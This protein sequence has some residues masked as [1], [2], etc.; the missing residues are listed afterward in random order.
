MLGLE[1]VVPVVDTCTVFVTVVLIGV[2]LFTLTVSVIVPEAPATR[3]LIVHV[4][5]P[6]DT[7]AHPEPAFERTNVV[8][9]A[10][11]SDTVT[12]FGASLGP[13]FDATIV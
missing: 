4:T 3:P 12:L 9:G 7:P 2:V 1:S 5:L 6:P 13:L 8:P 10:I 11:V